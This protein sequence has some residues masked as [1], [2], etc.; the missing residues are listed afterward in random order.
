MKSISGFPLNPKPTNFKPKTRFVDDPKRHFY[1][2]F[3]HIL[4]HCVD[5]PGR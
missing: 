5:G 1:L 4:L 3:M 2:I